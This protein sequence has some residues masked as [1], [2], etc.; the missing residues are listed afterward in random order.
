MRVALL[1]LIEQVDDLQGATMPRSLLPF[2]ASSLADIQLDMALSL[3]CEKII[4]I[5]KGIVPGLIDLQRAAER[6]G[7]QFHLAGGAR[8]L[9]A[10][11]SPADELIVLADGLLPLSEEGRNALSAGYAI[12]VVPVDPGLSF[13]FERIDLDR[14]WAGAMRLP[15]NL[16]ER[17]GEL[18]E[19]VDVA[20]AL[21]RIALQARVPEQVL[22]TRLMVQGEWTKVRSVEEARS[23][24]QIWVSLLCRD[25]KPFSPS[26]WLAGR[27]ASRCGPWLMQGRGGSLTLSL[28]ALMLFIAALGLGRA[29]NPMAGLLLFAAGMVLLDSGLAVKRLERR[30]KPGN[31]LPAL[32]LPRLCDI[33]LVLLLAF[34]IGPQSDWQARFFVPL[35]VLSLCTLVPAL[36]QSRWARLIGDRAVLATASALVMALTPLLPVMRLYSL[37]LLVIALFSA[38]LGHRAETRK[39]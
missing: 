6:A 8:N 36:V 7:A 31:D 3:G 33:A 34:A 1:S 28:A 4:C 5:G 18:P 37:C 20:S 19:D 35:V 38:G 26:A 9:A 14:A 16:I 32:L 2:G 12:A 27:I 17:L 13:G 25:E 30:R 15:G 22:D 10:L 23:R 29:I 11:V 39:R 24:E 21:L